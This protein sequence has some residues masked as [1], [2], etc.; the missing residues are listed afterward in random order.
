[1]ADSAF[2]KSIIVVL[3]VLILASLATAFFNLFRG[4]DS[5]ETAT[6][7]ALTVRV[8]LSITLISIIAILYALGIITPNG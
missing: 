5:D 8:V 2:A 1:M 4:R 3:F 6:V 7:K